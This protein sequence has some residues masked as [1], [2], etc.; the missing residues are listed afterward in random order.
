MVGEAAS[1]TGPVTLTFSA[2]DGVDGECDIPF[3]PASVWITR[4]FAPRDTEEGD[5]DDI[6][7]APSREP[8]VI[9]RTD[10]ATAGQ[11][12]TVVDDND[13]KPMPKG[14]YTYTGYTSWQWGESM[15]YN[16]VTI[17]LFE[18]APDS[19]TNV[20][21]TLT[22]EGALI[23]WK[24]STKG[25]G[26]PE[27][28]VDPATL[29]YDVYR[30]EDYSL[31]KLIA[32]NI[33]ETE[34]IDPLDDITTLQTMSWRVI[35][36][37]DLGTSAYGGITP[38]IAV[39]PAIEMPFVETFSKYDYDYAADNIWSVEQIDNTDLQWYV[40]ELAYGENP[41]GEWLHFYPQGYPN[42]NHGMAYVSVSQYA[43]PGTTG[44][45]TSR[46]DFSKYATGQLTFSYFTH[47]DASG[48]LAIDLTFFGSREPMTLW[49]GSLRGEEEGWKQETVSFSG[50]DD[51]DMMQL[52]LLATLEK[53]T[54]NWY[55]PIMVDY[56]KLEGVDYVGVDTLPV[57]QNATTEYFNLQGMR[58]SN[59]AKG[60]IVIRRATGADGRTSTT[61]VIY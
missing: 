30:Y 37:N 9:W 22:D 55:I 52:R 17:G 38:A 29:R 19:P 18:D 21:A 25:Q 15:P 23:T 12:F 4:T 31:T 7:F 42:A 43:T 49:E 33:A 14:V 46:M 45:T 61:K 5:D 40:G 34:V 44:Y 13:G 6:D 35:A 26:Y 27:G 39:G 47:P 8:V 16:A 59:P 2:P 58:I 50:L 11:A 32:E 60:Q 51:V 48:K 28:Y 53:S 56:I 36:H 20:R 24:P 1:I 54:T 10:N 41:K 3:V 57:D